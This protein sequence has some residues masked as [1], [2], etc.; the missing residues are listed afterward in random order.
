MVTEL[1]QAGIG[2]L[3]RWLHEHG[4]THIKTNIWQPDSADIMAKGPKEEIFVQVK[5]VQSP[6]DQVLLNATDK[7]ALIEMAARLERIPY[8]A[9][10]MVDESKNLIGEI[11]WERLG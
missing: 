1:V 5:T 2:H 7:F 8:I 4:Y 11:T 9:Y 6:N 10:V 3:K